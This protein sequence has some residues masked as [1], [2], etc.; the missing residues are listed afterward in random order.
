MGWSH[1]EISLE[2]LLNLIKGF[3]DILILA[4]GFQS[5]GSIA[6]WDAQNI[7]KAVQWG[8]FFENVFKGLTI[9]D[10]YQGSVVEL[11]AAL[12][13]MTSNP[14][15]PQGLRHLSSSTLARGR[16]FVLK[17][18]IQ[19]LQLR[20]EHLIAFLTATVEMDLDT[21][22]R[23]E[24]DC[25][26]VYLGKLMLKNTHTNPQSPE[27][28]SDI[29]MKESFSDNLS[30]FVIQ[31]LSERQTSVSRV[32]SVEKGLAVLSESLKWVGYGKLCGEINILVLTIRSKEQLVELESW[33]KWRSRN[34][35][36]FLD[37]R[38][39]KLVSGAKLVFSAPKVQW[40]QVFE[41][42]NVASD[43]DLLE[44]IELS[45]LGIVSSSWNRLIE[46]FMSVSSDL[47][48]ISM[49][50]H[51]LHNLLQQRSQFLHSKEET[52]HSKENGIIEY[53]TVL[54]SSQP[55]QLWKLSPILTAIA[56]PTCF[57]M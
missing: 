25:L 51:E 23:T 39:V 12:L 47:L 41:R 9:T 17:H 48:P 50:Y 27:S 57:H 3:V 40:L 53:L 54:L 4:S 21:L 52:R 8:I 29:D 49:Q 37:K 32:L 38:T 55:H 13:E 36:Y 33:N 7:K 5:S 31:E 6:T 20:D 45:L 46:H 19:T 30:E 24:Y 43:D 44:I 35:S 16:D 11:D 28:V 14:Y 18:L 2:D 26:N 34:L 56:I 15:F 22:R 42:L 1:P 10:D